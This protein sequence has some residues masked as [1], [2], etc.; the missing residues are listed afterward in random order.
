[1]KS[2]AFFFNT[3]L[4]MEC[5]AFDLFIVSWFGTLSTMVFK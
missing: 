5:L 1:M 4:N 3:P 2:D